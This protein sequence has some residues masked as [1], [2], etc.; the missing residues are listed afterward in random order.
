MSRSRKLVSGVLAVAVSTALGLSA[1]P[2]VAAPQS[3]NALGVIAGKEVASSELKDQM[4]SMMPTL[5]TEP[6]NAVVDTATKVGLGTFPPIVWAGIYAEIN[7]VRKA[8]GVPPL[9]PCPKATA[10]ALETA[11]VRAARNGVYSDLPFDDGYYGLSWIGKPR[12]AEAIVDDLVSIPWIR[13]NLAD[14]SLTMQGVGVAQMT[15]G[16]SLVVI[17]AH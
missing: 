11:Q 6:I 2:A 9:K 14:P 5:P 12:T 15:N 10:D 4:M 13:K 17:L 8:E 3:S 1:T 7:E 16:K